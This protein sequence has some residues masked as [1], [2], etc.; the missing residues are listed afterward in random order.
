VRLDW[1][2]F[3]RVHSACSLHGFACLVTGSTSFES[4]DAFGSLHMNDVSS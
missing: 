4:G 3:H 2:V 1:L